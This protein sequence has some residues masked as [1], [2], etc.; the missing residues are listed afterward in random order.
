MGEPAYRATQLWQGIYQQLWP[1]LEEFTNLSKPLR[2]KLAGQYDLNALK[3]VKSIESKDSQTQKM[4]FYLRDGLSI[5]AVL[6]RY[7]NRQ[8]LCISSQ[9]GCPMGCVFCATG[10]MGFR[11]N[12]TSGEIV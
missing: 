2:E 9:S 3:P 11:R 7:K 5:E 8:T 1:S 10:Q 6:M 12:L 4:L